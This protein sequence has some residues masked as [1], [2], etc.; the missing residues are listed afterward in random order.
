[1]KQIVRNG[2][3]TGRAR[4]QVPT[5][6]MR[7][8][9]RHAVEDRAAGRARTRG[10]DGSAGA[11]PS[12]ISVSI[13]FQILNRIINQ[14]PR[15]PGRQNRIQ[16]PALFLPSWVPYSIGLRRSTPIGTPG[17]FFMIVIPSHRQLACAIDRIGMIPSRLPC[18][19]VTISETLCRPSASIVQ[20]SSLA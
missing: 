5:P 2:F 13:L 10:N 11:S 19:P 16:R 4:Q 20:R 17:F 1:M 9:S 8:S 3:R 12:Q 15:R 6:S 18:N 14:E 7:G